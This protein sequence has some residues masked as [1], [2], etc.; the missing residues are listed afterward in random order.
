MAQT[1]WAGTYVASWLANASG[2][3]FRI[4]ALRLEPLGGLWVQNLTI[5][6]RGAE[7]NPWLRV[8]MLKVEP[9]W[10]NLL[11]GSHKPTKVVA[12]GADLRIR[13]QRNGRFEVD[14][15]IP[16]PRVGATSGAKD[17]RLAIQIRRSR[18]A[19]FDE[20]N[21][22]QLELNELEGLID[23]QLRGSTK[24]KARG[25]LCGSPIE[26]HAQVDC[27]PGTAFAGRIRARGD[28]VD[29]GRVA[30]ANWIPGVAKESST[31]TGCLNWNMD[32]RSE[33]ATCGE[34]YRSLEGQGFLS[35]APIRIDVARL[36]ADR[37]RALIPAACARAG[38]LCC[39]FSVQGGCP[40]I[41]QVTIKVGRVPLIFASAT[42]S[43]SARARSVASFLLPDS[44][45]NRPV[46]APVNVNRVGQSQ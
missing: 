14:D 4:G 44:P 18:L 7:A 35:V 41:D 29:I 2:K 15:L 8:E 20:P 36:V 38:A 33:G 21:A 22:T 10:V 24:A 45:S 43:S 17:P 5:A 39:Q 23:C 6:E 9:N 34:V 19:L 25:R 11:T 31:L 37:R 12:I 27:L 42:R 46:S 28:D 16:A 40:A 13:R 1:H 26:L 30:L 3:S 32:F